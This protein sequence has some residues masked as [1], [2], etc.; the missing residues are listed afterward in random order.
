RRSR[1]PSKNTFASSDDV[2]I[3][4][5]TIYA[6]QPTVRVALRKEARTRTESR[7]GDAFSRRKEG[8]KAEPTLILVLKHRCN[9]Q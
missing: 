3:L 1:Y 5:I 6:Q 8:R 2:A 7:R 4:P 9:Q